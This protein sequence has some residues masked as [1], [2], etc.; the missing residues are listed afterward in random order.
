MKKI[1]ICLIMTFA[2]ICKV[3][4]SQFVYIDIV[5]DTTITLS[6]GIYQLDLDNDGIYDY[7]LSLFKTAFPDTLNVAG[8]VNLS[9][10]CYVASWLL[11]GCDYLAQVFNLNDPV[12]TYAN[13]SDHATVG[14][15]TLISGTCMYS[16]P[17]NGLS[18]KYMGLKMIKNGIT[19]Y[20]WVGIDV[21][22]HATWFTMK[23]YGSNAGHIFA[24]QKTIE[25]VPGNSGGNSGL[26][27][28]PNPA[29]DKIIILKSA[30][31]NDANISIY[32]VHGQLAAQQFLNNVK[33]EIDVKNLVPGVYLLKASNAEKT[34]TIKIIKE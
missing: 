8:I 13:W 26:V 34:I 28:Y 3:S 2:L 27:V 22:S 25:A 33:T 29:Q 32:N 7:Q 5:P 16:G 6:G 18:N 20:G 4:Y 19:F 30:E 21:G 17:F 10:S 11:D 1:I 23:D 31:M 15:F 12:N 14:Q 9:D 24:G